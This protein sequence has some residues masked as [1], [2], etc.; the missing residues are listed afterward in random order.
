MRIKE[1][2]RATFEQA[3]IDRM[4]E[5]GF[6]EVEIR[7]ECLVRAGDGYLDGSVDAYWHFWNAA[8]DGLDAA[9]ATQPH[10]P[11]CAD[12][13]CDPSVEFTSP[14]PGCAAKPPAELADAATEDWEIWKQRAL[15]AEQKV[16][17]QDQIIDLL[18]QEVNETNGP[19]FMGEPVLNTNPLV[20]VPAD[21]DG[22][23]A[24][25][26]FWAGFEAA[27]S[28]QEASNIRQA[29]NE[30]KLTDGFARVSSSEAGGSV[31]ITGTVDEIDAP[32][33]PFLNAE[34]QKVME[35]G[36]IETYQYHQANGG[37]AVLWDGH[38][39]HAMAVTIRDGF[40]RTR[41]VRILAPGPTPAA[42]IDDGEQ[43][44]ARMKAAGMMPISEMLARGPLDGFIKHAGVNDLTSFGQWIEMR[45]RSCSEMSARFQLDKREDDELYEW[46]VAHAAV[47]GEVHVNFKAA[48]GATGA[49]QD[50]V[51]ISGKDIEHLKHARR[52][53]TRHEFSPLRVRQQLAE[54]INAMIT[55]KTAGA[56]A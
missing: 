4:K 7:V 21:Q 30:F 10:C 20:S 22:S 49:L 50:G 2:R 54:R 35:T 42:K 3:V 52:E 23:S 45:R 31:L 15:E 12:T 56:V 11:V 37:V 43:L 51:F 1:S 55:P 14:C 26:S 41:C 6:L 53:L 25:K 9:P 24:Q 47:F 33:W 13:G 36:R 17:H 29:W 5:S 27:R 28:D 46:V 32:V 16:R 39:I 18:T 48:I 19:A 34:A 38:R 40:N 8:V 44:A